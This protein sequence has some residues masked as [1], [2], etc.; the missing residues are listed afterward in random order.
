M[1]SEILQ[2]LESISTSDKTKPQV[3]VG[4]VAAEEYLARVITNLNSDDENGIETIGLA[5][6]EPES[7]DLAQAVSFLRIGDPYRR[8][9]LQILKLKIRKPAVEISIQEILDLYQL[10][11]EFLDYI[12]LMIQA[13]DALVQLKPFQGVIDVYKFQSNQAKMRLARRTILQG[14]VECWDEDHCSEPI[15]WKSREKLS[16][17][18]SSRNETVLCETIDR[19]ALTGFSC[20]SAQGKDTL[21]EFLVQAN[22]EKNKMLIDNLVLCKQTYNSLLDSGWEP[23]RWELENLPM[24]SEL[25]LD[26]LQ[27]TGVAY[28]KEIGEEFILNLDD[29][30]K[31]YR[32]AGTPYL[33]NDDTKK[34]RVLAPGWIYRGELIIQPKVREIK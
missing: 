9:I 20:Q 2:M 14:L 28:E 25:F 16:E 19:I 7:P 29:A 15:L 27:K 13:I 1:N 8:S 18:I 33:E 11:Q 5:L 21:K 32:Y 17:I 24:T 12:R 26:F 31:R 22:D 30:L 10:D 3:P 4:V 34:V 6:L 23:D